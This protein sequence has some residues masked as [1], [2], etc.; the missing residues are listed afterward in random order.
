MRLAFLASHRGSNVQA[1]LSAIAAGRINATPAVV[2]SN[3]SK[4]GVLAI[5][6][7]FSVPALCCSPKS[8]ASVEAHDAA[9]CEI[10]DSQAV[11][12]IVLGGYVIK[13]GPE[14][15]RRYSGR[16]VNIHPSLLPKFG[17]V[18]MY[19]KNVH[20][21]VLKAKEKFTGATVHLIDAEYDTGPI[22]AQASVAVDPFDTVESLAQKVLELEHELYVTALADITSG[23][24]VLPRLA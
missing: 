5:A 23:K 10:L 9:L 6:E 3:N 13:I 1:I 12:L 11:D 24:L 2:V 21:A 16:I 4:A 18:G 19:G 15:L 14:V 20:E 8:F 22:L 7:S 17:G